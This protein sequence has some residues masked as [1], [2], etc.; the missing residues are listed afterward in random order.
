MFAVPASKVLEP[1]VSNLT[2]SNVP[3]KD[4]V[5]VPKSSQSSVK[6][7]NFPCQVLELD[8]IKCHSAIPRVVLLAL[9]K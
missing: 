4:L 5:Q 2:L 9:P 1:V 7:K 6:E 8:C 3:D